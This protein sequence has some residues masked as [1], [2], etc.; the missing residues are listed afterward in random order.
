MPVEAT[1]VNDARVTVSGRGSRR[2][3]NRVDLDVWLPRAFIVGM[4]AAVLATQLLEVLL[5]RTVLITQLVA[6][7]AAAVLGFIAG[8]HSYSSR[9]TRK[10]WQ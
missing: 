3:E 2:K 7:A 6:A 9:E 4:S 1:P 5:V 8:A 10:W